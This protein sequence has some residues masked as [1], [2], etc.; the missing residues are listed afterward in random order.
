MPVAKKGWS[1]GSAPLRPANAKN[2]NAAQEEKP[3]RMFTRIDNKD[4]VSF[5]AKPA[6]SFSWSKPVYAVANP[7]TFSESVAAQYSR[8]PVLGL[9]HEVLQYIRTASREISMELWCSYHVIR[10]R[11]SHLQHDAAVKRL[12]A[13]RNFFESLLMPSKARLAPPVVNVF[14]PNAR[15]HFKGVVDSLSITYERFAFNGEPI[16]FMLDVDFIEVGR[17]LM[18]QSSVSYN[19][20]GARSASA[21]DG[22]MAEWEDL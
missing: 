10:L 7:E 17:G 13:Y 20:W 16:E 21:S 15:L 5:R 18:T 2:L 14:W 3:V 8:R 11:N 22:F 4:M 1:G 12:F 9:S 19:G 6:Q